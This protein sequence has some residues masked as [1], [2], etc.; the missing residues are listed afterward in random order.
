[1]T[2][3][4]L[5]PIEGIASLATFL[6]NTFLKPNGTYQAAI[7]DHNTA[8]D[9]AD[10]TNTLTELAILDSLRMPTSRPP[11]KKKTVYVWQCVSYHMSSPDDGPR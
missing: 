8:K 9:A 2:I 5:D 1:M 10:L 11:A 4:L 7:G 6:P 3:G